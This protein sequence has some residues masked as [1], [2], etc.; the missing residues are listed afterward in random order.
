MISP[1]I[2]VV[3]GLILSHLEPIGISRTFPIHDRT[4][5]YPFSGGVVYNGTFLNDI[6]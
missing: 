3:K 2:D 1:P 4:F 5:A 6:P